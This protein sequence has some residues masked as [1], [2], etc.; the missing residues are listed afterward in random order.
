MRTSFALLLVLLLGV[1]VSGAQESLQSSADAP[2]GWHTTA[3]RDEIRPAFT[4]EQ[5]GGP[6]GAPCLVIKADARQGQDGSWVRV[7]QVTGGKH[8][9]FSALYKA[10]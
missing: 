4:Y 8:Y 6:D 7:F 9:R 2:S 5:N 1:L 3:P 10:T